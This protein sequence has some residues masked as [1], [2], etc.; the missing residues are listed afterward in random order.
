YSISVAF[1]VMLWGCPYQTLVPLGEPTEKV[2]DKIIGSWVSQHDFNKESPSYYLINTSDS[3]FYTIGHF[4][5]NDK[6]SSYTVKHYV[7]HSTTIDS[8]LFLNV[9]GVGSKDFL[10]HRIELVKEGFVL[11]EVSDNVDE[12][13]KS[14]EEMQA[15]FKKHM[16]LSFFYNKEET[17]LVRKSE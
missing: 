1:V 8:N 11:H 15:F 16:H 13:F 6:D 3:I 17:T 2:N 9:Q 10:M 12:K 7:A 5:F 4:T 14:S